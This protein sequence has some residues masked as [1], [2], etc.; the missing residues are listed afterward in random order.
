MMTA[1]IINIVLIYW[2]NIFMAKFQVPHDNSH[3]YLQK[4]LSLSEENW[5]DDMM[6]QAKIVQYFV[7]ASDAS[8][9]LVR[10]IDDLIREKSA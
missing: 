8:T 6:K 5:G 9:E 3:Q 2:E 1:A 10:V 7:Q 4:A